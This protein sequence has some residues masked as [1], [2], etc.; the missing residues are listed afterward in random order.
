MSDE[1]K[2][3]KTGSPLGEGLTL[4]GF[5]NSIGVLWVLHRKSLGH[6]YEAGYELALGGVIAGVLFALYYLLGPR[7]SRWRNRR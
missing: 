1:Q 3:Q 5:S 7:I 4:L 2:P 6:F